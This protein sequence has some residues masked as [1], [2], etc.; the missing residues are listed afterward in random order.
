M[1]R[2]ANR[3]HEFSNGGI[4]A[5]VCFAHVRCVFMHILSIYALTIDSYVYSIHLFPTHDVA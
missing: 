5:V 3:L 4:P 1:D 2:F